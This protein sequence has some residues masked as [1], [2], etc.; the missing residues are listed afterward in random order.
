MCVLPAGML[1]LN[2]LASARSLPI[3]DLNRFLLM[4]QQLI[5]PYVRVFY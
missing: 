2:P 4:L 1:N 5:Y 3:A